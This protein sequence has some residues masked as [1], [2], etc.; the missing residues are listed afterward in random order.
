MR[1]KRTKGLVKRSLLENSEKLRWEREMLERTL[2]DTHDRE[3]L[4]LGKTLE[5]E[6]KD[7]SEEFQT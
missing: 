7:Y 5:K 4:Q 3:V 1:E 2:R 6:M